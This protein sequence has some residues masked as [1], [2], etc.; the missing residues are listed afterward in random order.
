MPVSIR[1][2]APPSDPLCASSV[3]PNSS[4]PGFYVRGILQ[5]RILEWVAVF[6]LQATFLTQGS[7]LH[8]LC[9]QAD[10]LPLCHLESPLLI[11]LLFSHW[12]V[13]V[14]LQAHGLQHARLPCPSP[15]P[16]A[17]SHSC[18]LSQWHHLAISS[19]VTA[20]CSCP[21]SFRA[22]GS[23]PGGWLFPLGGQSIGVSASVL[24]MT[25]QGWLPL[26]LTGLISLQSKG[27]SR[28]FSSTTVGKH[29]FFSTQPSL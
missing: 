21:Q 9:W 18:P 25:I 5:A 11:P 20:F 16:G 12:V 14:S 15:S 19:S 6:L 2:P 13:S 17:C 1:T 22:S 7:N 8:L 24:P 27:L 28:V 4:L 26:R 23:F 3:M 29:Q 10:T